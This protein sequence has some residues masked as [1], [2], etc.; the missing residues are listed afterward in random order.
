[1]STDGSTLAVHAQGLTKSFGSFLALDRLDLSVPPGTV[2]GYLGPNGA[3]KT[4]TIRLLMGLLR[5]SSGRASILGRDVT[6]ER[7]LVHRSVGYLPG[8]FTAYPDMTAQAY[9]RYLADLHGRGWDDIARLADRLQ[10]S[11]GRR[12][13]TLSHGNRQKVGL[14]QALMGSPAVLVLDEPT[15]GLDPLMQREFQALVR[16][17]RADGRTVFLSSHVLTEVEAVADTIGMVRDGRLLLV[18]GIDE[19][20]A[21][22]R[23]RLDL[24]VERVPPLEGLRELPGV[25]GVDVVERT[26]HIVVDGS[27]TELFRFLAP[28]GI[29]KVVAHEVDLEDVFLAYYDEPPQQEAA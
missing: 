26:L 5:P 19:L 21:R 14:V 18:Q 25:R 2:F 28:S 6:A 11:L 20:K 4:T 24:T 13:G 27:T 16:E 15:S 29:S 22:A 1:M 17:A 12:I 9:L 3:G 10:L 7:D 23:R 8:D